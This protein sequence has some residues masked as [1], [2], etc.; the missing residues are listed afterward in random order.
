MLNLNADVAMPLRTKPETTV[1]KLA[2]RVYHPLSY[3]E[4]RKADYF[5]PGFFGTF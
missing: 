2:G 1:S 5:C 4:R 3:T